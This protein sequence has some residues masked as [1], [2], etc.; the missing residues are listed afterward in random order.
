[1]LQP[2]GQRVADD[3]DVVI[4]PKFKFVRVRGVQRA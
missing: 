1:V 3:A 2:I 4:F